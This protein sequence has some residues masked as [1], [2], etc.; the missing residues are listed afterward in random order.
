MKFDWSKHDRNKLIGIL[1]TVGAIL[2]AVV[3]LYIWRSEIGKFF[4]TFIGAAK[5]LLYAMIVA[6][7]LWPLLR[8]FEK[9]VF[10]FIETWTGS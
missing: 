3:L 5:P 1:V 9:H 10:S 2:L 7:I 8:F 4:S 6:Y